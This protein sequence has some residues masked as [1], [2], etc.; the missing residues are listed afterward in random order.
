MNDTP[1]YTLVTTDPH[2][3]VIRTTNHTWKAVVRLA[4]YLRSRNYG[5]TF[6]F[7]C[8]QPT[9]VPDA[10]LY[11]NARPLARTVRRANRDP[12]CQSTHT[13]ECYGP[14]WQCEDCHKT[15]CCAEGTTDHSELCDDCW[16]ARFHPVAVAGMVF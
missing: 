11:P 6:E 2:G 16:M 5:P 13:G 1:L 12:Q 4:L 10:W 8:E 14:L 15:V 9:P 7:K 3:N